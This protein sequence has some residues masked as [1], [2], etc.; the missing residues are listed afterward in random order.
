M[1]HQ[2]KSCILSFQKFTKSNI[3]IITGHV[4]MPK[5]WYFQKKNVHHTV[6]KMNNPE[7]YFIKVSKSNIDKYHGARVDAEKMIFTVGE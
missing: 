2:N 3:D 6:G 4:L 1:W 7:H 5:K